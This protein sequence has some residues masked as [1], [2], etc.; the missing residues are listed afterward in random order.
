MFICETVESWCA[1][2][3]LHKHDYKPCKDN[4]LWRGEERGRG[5]KAQHKK[6]R[7][8][9]E[10]QERSISAFKFCFNCRALP[11]ANKGKTNKPKLAVSLLQREI[12]Y[13]WFHNHIFKAWHS[14]YFLLKWKINWFLMVLK[15]FPHIFILNESKL[16]REIILFFFSNSDHSKFQTFREYNLEKEW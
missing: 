16:W 7:E 15:I 1:F 8:K 2:V 14:I 3:S 4:W 9:E 10:L 11:I 13:L 6:G 5:R 12:N